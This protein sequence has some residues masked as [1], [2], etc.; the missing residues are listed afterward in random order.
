[1]FYVASGIGQLAR[2][3]GM[4][5]GSMSAAQATTIDI[6]GPAKS[7]HETVNIVRTST[8]R[9]YCIAFL[10]PALGES[11]FETTGKKLTD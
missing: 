7:R 9:L 10:K 3:F 5:T 2:S 11:L 6:V 4:S 8:T 1:M